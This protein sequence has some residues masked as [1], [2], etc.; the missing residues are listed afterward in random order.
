MDTILILAV[1]GSI[2]AGLFYAAQARPRFVLKVVD[3]QLRVVQGHPPPSFIQEA[4]DIVRESRLPSGVIKGYLKHGR[5][6]LSFSRHVPPALQQRLR[7]V[8]ALRF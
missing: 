1:A 4:E 7:N 5:P 3:G 8:L 2:T 6:V